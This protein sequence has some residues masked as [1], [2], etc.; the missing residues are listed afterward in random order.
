MCDRFVI[1]MPHN[2]YVG[3]EEKLLA[4]AVRNLKSLLQL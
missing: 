2:K 4:A 1:L 3:K